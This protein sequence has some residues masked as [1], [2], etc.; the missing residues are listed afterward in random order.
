M[1]KDKVLLKCHRDIQYNTYLRLFHLIQNK[2]YKENTPTFKL[3]SRSDTA[4][5]RRALIERVKTF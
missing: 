4:R 3:P 1:V 5:R 2:S